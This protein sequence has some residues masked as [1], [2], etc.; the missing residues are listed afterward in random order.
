[1]ALMSEST[2]IHKAA[3]ILIRDKKLLVERSKGKEFL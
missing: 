1:M 3:G 2:D